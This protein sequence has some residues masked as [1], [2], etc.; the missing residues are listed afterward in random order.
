[1]TAVV[2]SLWIGE[3]TQLEMLSIASHIQQ[4]HEYHLW[5]YKHFDLPSSVVLE[6]ANEILPKSEIFTYSTGFGAGSVSAFSNIF[7]YKLLLERGGWWSDCDVVAL[8]PFNFDDDYVFASERT[9]QASMH[10]TTCIIKCPPGA[11]LMKYCLDVANSK[12]RKKLVWGE[13]GP[14]LL[15]SAIFSHEM[16]SHVRPPDAFCPVDWFH[17]VSDPSVHFP[18]DLSNSWA[19]HLWHQVWDSRST[20][21]S[22]PDS[23]YEK[24]K[25]QFKVEE[26]L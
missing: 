8:K 17:S 21:A 2:N 3:L 6:D 1:M 10:P 24:L 15:S 25:N 20:N 4:G 7:R 18:V 12:D 26:F 19:V 9:R 13:I 14:R 22:Y 16:L 5:T 11:L 23:L